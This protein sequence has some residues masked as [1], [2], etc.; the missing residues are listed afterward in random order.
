M[1]EVCQESHGLAGLHRPLLRAR[2]VSAALGRG[3]MGVEK[4]REG[5]GRGGVEGRS[6]L[7]P[8]SPDVLS[9]RLEQGQGQHGVGVPLGAHG[10][11]GGGRDAGAP[12]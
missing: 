2:G 10:S 8:H 11:G 4:G 1:P 7:L 12:A 5:R 3:R 9:K 6:S